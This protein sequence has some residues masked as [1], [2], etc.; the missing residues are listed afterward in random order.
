MHFISYLRD[1]QV[2]VYELNRILGVE[3]FDS[4]IEVTK[5]NL[6]W[7][8]E[9]NETSEYLDSIKVRITGF[10]IAFNWE[11]SIEEI[12]DSNELRKLLSLENTSLSD[13]KISGRIMLTID[14]YNFIGE[15]SWRV[16]NNVKFGENGNYEFNSCEVHLNEKVLILN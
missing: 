16:E 10:Y 1:S 14:S 8:I 9:L 11:V 15:D 12:E 6:K 2:K 13:T 7:S 5:F 4:S 3:E